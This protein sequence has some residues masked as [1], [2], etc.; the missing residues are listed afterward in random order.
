MTRGTIRTMG[1]VTVFV[2]VLALAWFTRKVLLLLFAGLLVALV[3]T[4]FTHL[5]RR[6]LP[7][8]HKVALAIVLVLLCGV[9]AGVIAIGIPAVAGQFAQL[10]EEIPKRTA[11][12]QKWVQES[13]LIQKINE[14]L[15]DLEKM[16]PSGGAGGLTS[17]FSSTFE[18]VSSLVF[19]AFTGIFAAASPNLYRRIVVK[20]FTP[21]LRPK[22]EHTIT[23]LICTLKYWLLGQT[24]SMLVVGIVTGVALAIAGVPLALALG[25]VG[26]F[27]EFIPFIGPLLS[28]I[29][30]MLLASSDGMDKVLIVAAIFAGIQFMEGNILQPIVQ[31]RAID[32]PPIVTL[33]ALL[34]FGG[35]FG[36]LGMFVAAPLAAVI[37][38]LVEE[39]YLHEY[40]GTKDKL[41]DLS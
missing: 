29:P 8:G 40:L 14:I 10:S 23:R 20:L 1:V 4:T 11:E 41:L 3:L 36:L 37:M 25:I 17:F 33:V 24:V 16:M 26:G 34:V 21:R 13:P 2:I 6:I 12:L 9:M 39:L 27:L 31:K 15:P 35:A 19:I 5:L 30:A 38:V 7:V 32:L 18:A 22:A 28:A